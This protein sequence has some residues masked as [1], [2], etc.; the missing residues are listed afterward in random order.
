MQ[1]LARNRGTTYLGGRRLRAEDPE[2]RGSSVEVKVQDLGGGADRDR[3]DIGV[4]E[5]VDGDRGSRARGARGETR[6]AGRDVLHGLL[7]PAR[8]GLSE[9]QV[10]LLDGEGAHEVVVR[11]PHCNNC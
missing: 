6:V 10:R 1:A 3:R 5:A 11:V 8:N 4:V 7:E 9:L 2:V